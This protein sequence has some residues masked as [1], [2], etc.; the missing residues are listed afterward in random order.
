[1]EKS[2]QNDGQ[3]LMNAKPQKEKKERNILVLG[4]AVGLFAFA[5]ML[6]A[7]TVTDVVSNFW[8]SFRTTSSLNGNN[9]V[10]DG[11][12]IGTVAESLMPSVVSVLTS[13]SMAGSYDGAG[14]GII[15]SSNGYILTNKHVIEGSRRVAVV[16]NGEDMYDDVTVVGVDPLNDV[17]FLKINGGGNNFRPAPFGDSQSLMIGQQVIAIGNSLGLF[18]NSVTAG[19]ISG[20]GRSIN[21]STSGGTH[22]ERLTDMIQTDAAI[23]QGNSGGPL[24]NAGGQVVGINTA[25]SVEGQG[26]GFAIP[27]GAVRGMLKHLLETGRVERAFLG[28]MFVDLD[29]SVAA[30]YDLEQSRGAFIHSDGDNAVV[31]GSPADRAG[32]RTGDI[33]THVNDTE[34]GR[35]GSLSTVIGE[36]AVGETVRLTVIRGGQTLHLSATLVAHGS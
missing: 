19:V 7:L 27:I 24:V 20:M 2:E 22:A 18:A 14:T 11:A 10:F 35:A 33:I 17:A 16:V 34:L 9:S 5:G 21:A 30:R 8:P 23:N 13:G 25:V 12:T 6:L 26:I 29:A 15:V 3:I 1:M 36:Y 31:S 32:I 4:V 28:V